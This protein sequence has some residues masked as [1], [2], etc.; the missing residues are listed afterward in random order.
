MACTC[1]QWGVCEARSVHSTD[2]ASQTPHWR[3]VQAI[4][5]ILAALVGIHRR[6]IVPRYR[7]GCQAAVAL[8]TRDLHYTAAGFLLRNV[9]LVTSWRWE[10]EG[11]L[12]H[13]RP[14]GLTFSLPVVPDAITIWNFPGLL[15]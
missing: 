1:L 10:R 5:E 8:R 15:T 7:R 4:T 9:E 11:K 14:T 2:R 12:W 3:Q 6:F 13:E